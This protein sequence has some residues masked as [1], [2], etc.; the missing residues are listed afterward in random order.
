MFLDQLKQS[1]TILVG[2]VIAL[3]LGSAEMAPAAQS[4]AIDPSHSAV[5]FSIRHIVSNV[6]GRF[7]KF[8]G[9]I[10]YDPTDVTKSSVDV[11]IDAATIST[12]NSRRDEHLRSSDFFEVEKYPSIAFKS[13]KIEK[14]GERTFNITGNLTIH[15]VTKPAILK[16]ELL[17]IASD[18]KFG[19]RAGFE[20]STSIDRKDFGVNWNKTLDNGGVVVG[21][22]VKIRL[23]IEATLQPPPSEK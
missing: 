3:L 19:D 8:G 23:G 11:T 15:G 13:T 14:S 22:E 10:E 2:G 12:D 21:E 9:S 18:P 7:T 5:E 4:Y 1:R 16:A 6:P 17:G 20:A